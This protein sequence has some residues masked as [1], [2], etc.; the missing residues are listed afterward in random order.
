MKAIFGSLVAL[1][2]L[3]VFSDRACSAQDNKKDKSDLQGIW[4]LVRFE[5]DGEDVEF[6]ANLPRWVIDGKTVRYGGETLA[7]IAV[8]P[9]AKPRGLD[10]AWAKPK[11]D[12]EA[13]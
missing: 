8:L 12:Y 6:A 3:A 1:T 7:T 13:I 4:K 5:R 10:L 9:D 2:L 11:R